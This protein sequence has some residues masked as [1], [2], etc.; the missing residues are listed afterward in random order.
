MLLASEISCFSLYEVITVKENTQYQPRTP[1]ATSYHVFS[2]VLI[3]VH[4]SFCKHMHMEIHIKVN[5]YVKINYDRVSLSETGMVPFP[6]F[7]RS[8][9]GD[10]R[11]RGWLIHSLKTLWGW[12]VSNRAEGKQCLPDLLHPQCCLVFVVVFLLL[13]GISYDT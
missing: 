8:L 13:F 2:S 10:V 6:R 4:V 9:S 12:V 7:S 5:I 11:K 1:Y 3:H